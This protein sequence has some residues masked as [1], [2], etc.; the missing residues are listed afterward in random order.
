MQDVQD[1]FAT[2][3]VPDE[4]PEHVVECIQG[5]TQELQEAIEKND[6]HE[7]GSEIADLI[8]LST[9]LAS[10]YHID[11]AQAVSAKIRRNADKY[12]PY[13]IAS[14]RER[15]MDEKTAMKT[16]KDQWDKTQDKRYR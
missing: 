12:D 15:G 4:E 8:L 10:L 9:R 16:L 3:A 5:E 14:M 11:L 6:R 7:I 1:V 13:K 2:L